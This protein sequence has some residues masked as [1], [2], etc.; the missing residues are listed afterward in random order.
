MGSLH[1]AWSSAAEQ[2]KA[3]FGEAFAKENYL[4]VHIIGSKHRM[5]AHD[6]H[7][8]QVIMIAEELAQRHVYP[9]IVE[10]ASHRL[11]EMLGLLAQGKEMVVDPFVVTL[12]V[13]IRHVGTEALIEL[14]GTIK[15]CTAHIEGHG[16]QVVV[17][18]LEIG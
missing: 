2:A 4:P 16:Q 10:C 5:A 12:F 13:G 6:A 18:C 17:D 1:S 7:T 15:L 3:K 9:M 11:V 14:L 8:L